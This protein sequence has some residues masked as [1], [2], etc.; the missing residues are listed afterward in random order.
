LLLLV[1]MDIASLLLSPSLLLP[2]VP[3]F[4]LVL[5]RTRFNFPSCLFFLHGMAVEFKRLTQAETVSA[6]SGVW[7][8]IEKENTSFSMQSC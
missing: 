7:K 6:A 1:Y 3:W 8:T 4:G 2:M 5:C